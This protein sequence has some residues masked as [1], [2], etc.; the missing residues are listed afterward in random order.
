M[1]SGWSGGAPRGPT[2]RAGSCLIVDLDAVSRPVLGALPCLREPEW[3]PSPPPCDALALRTYC[4][5]HPS[6]RGD[7]E[8]LEVSASLC[9]GVVALSFRLSPPTALD[10]VD[11]HN[12]WRAGYGGT[13]RCRGRRSRSRI[14]RS[15]VEEAR[16][17]LTRARCR[18]IA[19]RRAAP[20]PGGSRGPRCASGER[21]QD[22]LRG[23][24]RSAGGL[25][26][27]TVHASA[28]KRHPR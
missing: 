7:T 3:S 28:L 5:G 22:A 13:D 6:G 24:P 8:V 25:R 20:H 1:S 26:R 10:D 18:T 4:A 14:R 23:C 11:D 15:G 17:R 12:R 2:V 16:S 9:H 27:V 19:S 21:G